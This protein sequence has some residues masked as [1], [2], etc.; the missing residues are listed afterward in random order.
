MYSQKEYNPRYIVEL[1]KELR[2]KQT[3][4]EEIL[5]EVLRNRKLNNLKFRR[6]HPFG[7]YI[8]DFY[9]DEIKLVIELD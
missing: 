3:E 7:R 4:S 6:Q 2:Q 9:C 8:A 5:W 1:S